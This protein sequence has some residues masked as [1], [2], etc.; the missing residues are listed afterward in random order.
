M[1]M[2]KPDSIPDSIVNAASKSLAFTKM[3]ALGNDFVLVAEP[4]L[5]AVLSA[6]GL[7]L[8]AGLLSRL[9]AK[10]CDRH[11]GIGADGLIVA[12]PTDNPI[13]DLAWTFLNNDGSP[14]L[15]CGNGLRCLALWAVENGVAL[16]S[17]F[18]VLTGKGPIAVNFHGPEKIETDLGCPILEPGLIPVACKTNKTTVNRE[19]VT[20]LGKIFVTCVGMGNPH[21]VI[22]NVPF[23]PERY[24]EVAEEI[25]KHADFPEGVNVEFVR[26]KSRSEAE[27]IVYERGCGATLACASGAAAV[28]VAGVLTGCLEREATVMLPGGNLLVSWSAK[29]DHVRICGPASVS[30][31]GC[32]DVSAF[33]K[34]LMPS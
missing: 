25:Q 19:L 15:M 22:L 16:E 10:L 7:A 12:G 6:S 30:F 8:S 31:T 14:S 21:C 11:F 34:E 28:L 4:D 9:A 3:Q 17:Q 20:S 1:L 33:L 18:S 27:V 26:V 29:D 24:E 23:G 2:L 13:C 32:L 5:Q